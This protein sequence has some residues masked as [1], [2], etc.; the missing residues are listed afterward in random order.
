VTW[1]GYISAHLSRFGSLVQSQSKASNSTALGYGLGLLGVMIF[2]STLPV[3]K[4]ALHDFTPAFITFARGAVAQIAAIGLLWALGR[5]FPKAHWMAIL[6]GGV[7]TVFGFP[8]LMATALKTVPSAHGGVVLG[9]LPLM[10]AV[11]ATLLAGD[12]P[13]R[14][15]W[16]CAVFGAALVIWFSLR[17]SAMHVEA[18]DLWLLAAALSASFGYVIFGRLAK[19]MPAWETISWAL[20]MTAPISFIA[21]YLTYNSV[22]APSGFTPWL[23]VIFLGLFS[24]YLGFF[25]WNAGLAMGGIAKVGQVQLLQTFVTLALSAWLLN[26]QITTT[27]LVFALAVGFVV[28]IG[29]RARSAA[30]PG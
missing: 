26:E 15:F 8:L 2:G 7:A 9:V 28:W 17:D 12:R 24:Q 19:V 6:A 21:T 29:S 14:L 18:G 30:K 27:T 1:H 11:F 3:T 22:S 4:L 25:A 13:P 16:I 23:Y 20:V 5:K 10:T